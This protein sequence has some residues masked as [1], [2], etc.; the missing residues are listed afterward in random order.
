[1]TESPDPAM[2][3]SMVRDAR[4]TT[5]APMKKR[6]I[7]E[8]TWDELLA[9]IDSQAKTIQGIHEVIA[10]MKSNLG[11]HATFLEQL[12]VLVGNGDQL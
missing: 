2:L 1:M 5:H 7:N 10:N 8:A 9:L 11:S 6:T 3:M 12:E 4:E